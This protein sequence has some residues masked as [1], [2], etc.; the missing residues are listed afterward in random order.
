MGLTIFVK[1]RPLRFLCQ[2]VREAAGVIAEGNSKA[3][4]LRGVLEDVEE[5]VFLTTMLFGHLSSS[6]CSTE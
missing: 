2:A 4:T 3:A 1:F 5:T 6:K